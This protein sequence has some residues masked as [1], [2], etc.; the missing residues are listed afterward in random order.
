MTK[1]IAEVV[2]SPTSSAAVS[3]QESWALVN[4]VLPYL[5]SKLSESLQTNQQ[6]SKCNRT[7]FLRPYKSCKI[8]VTT[9]KW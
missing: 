7:Y 6:V 2:I 8:P 9:N 5:D 4:Q 3:D 1:T